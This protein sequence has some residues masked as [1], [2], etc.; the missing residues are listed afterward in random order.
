MEKL[1][2]NDTAPETPQTAIQ[3]S[4][5]IDIDSAAFH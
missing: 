2:D 3:A 4:S 5:T 1:A